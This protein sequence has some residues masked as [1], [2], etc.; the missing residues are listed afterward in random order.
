ME[1][2]TASSLRSFRATLSVLSVELCF[3]CGYARQNKQAFFSFDA[4]ER[5]ERPQVR[6]RQ[7]VQ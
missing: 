1:A 4:I 5:V 2:A 7:R 6:L 3:A